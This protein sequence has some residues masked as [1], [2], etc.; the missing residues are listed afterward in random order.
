MF[1][2][3]RD[4][5]KDMLDWLNSTM[6]KYTLVI[7]GARQI[8][9]T[10]LIQKFCK[11]NFNKTYYLDLSSNIGMDLLD[12]IDINK[13]KKL[14]I[15]N[16]LDWVFDDF[17]DNSSNVLFIDEIQQ[18][19]RV[20]NWI[21]E[22]TREYKINVI[23][24][25]S[26]LNIIAKSN[27]FKKPM[28]DIYQLKMEPLNFKEYLK[29]VNKEVYEKFLKID[30]YGSSPRKDYDSIKKCFNDY[31]ITGGF[32]QV[33]KDI[34]L[35]N[36]KRV[37]SIIEQ[38]YEV[39]CTESCEYFDEPYYADR[40][41]ECI[42]GLLRLLVREKKGLKDND[43]GK[44]LK[45]IEPKDKTLSLSKKEYNRTMGWLISSKVLGVCDKCIDCNPLSIVQNQRVYFNDVGLLSY[46]ASSINMSKSDLDGLI[47]ETYVYNY[48]RKQSNATPMFACYENKEIDFL[49]IHDGIKYGIEVKH[50]NVKGISVISALNKGLIDKVIFIKGDTYGD[51]VDNKI[52]TVPIYLLERFKFNNIAD[53]K[54]YRLNMFKN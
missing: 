48:L 5:Y 12:Y 15:R 38:I 17:E 24:S 40:F 44:D 37:D 8:G 33:V 53:N 51:N 7:T 54:V 29:A 30:L 34:V 16:Y 50:G 20:Y 28:G 4:L 14:T 43:L 10:F 21:R 3:E 42:K 41:S 23:V 18:S 26:Y 2:I 1:Y 46:L 27:L 22:L 36:G 45:R 25:G 47:C 52:L 9:K 35:N 49:F 31:L 32:P 13:G 11:D 19:P 39:Y 6:K